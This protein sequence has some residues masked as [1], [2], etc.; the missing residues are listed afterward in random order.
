MTYTTNDG[1]TLRAFNSLYVDWGLEIIK[2][3][4]TLYYNPSSL[5]IESYGFKTPDGMEYEE[6]EE[7]GQLIEWADED[8]RECLENEADILIEAYCE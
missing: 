7:N 2:E 4:K 3:G 6:A 1:Y 8:W 5:S